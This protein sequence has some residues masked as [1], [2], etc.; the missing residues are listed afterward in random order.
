MIHLSLSPGNSSALLQQASWASGDW[1]LPP[2][3]P[4]PPECVQW[5]QKCW[6]LLT[7]EVSHGQGQIQGGRRGKQW[8]G[9]TPFQSTTLWKHQPGTFKFSKQLR[10]PFS[11]MLSCT[12][13]L[14][15]PHI[16]SPTSSQDLPPAARREGVSEWEH[17]GPA[18]C[19]C[20]WMIAERGRVAEG[21]CLWVQKG[22]E[23]G[24]KILT[25]LRDFLK[26]PYYYYLPTLV[27][28]WVGGSREPGCSKGHC[29]H[30]PLSKIQNPPMVTGSSAPYF[31]SLPIITTK[32]QWREKYT[33]DS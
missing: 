25:C 1:I 19:C 6:R 27:L 32:H 14:L 4:A 9:F 12:A 28:G 24:G 15:S 10:I 31:L 23:G 21:M 17:E 5:S 22:R 33:C 20:P 8:H 7:P 18:C 26:L 3:A 30:M 11:S 2:T 13:P 16:P 29:S